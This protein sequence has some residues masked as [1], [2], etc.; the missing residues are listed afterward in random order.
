MTFFSPR[1]LLSRC[2]KLKILLLFFL[3]LSFLLL[4]FLLLLPCLH[5]PKSRV[6]RLHSLLLSAS[7]AFTLHHHQYFHY[8]LLPFS[9]FLCSLFLHQLSSLQ[10]PLLPS[11]SGRVPLQPPHLSR[12]RDPRRLTIQCHLALLLHQTNSNIPSRMQHFHHPL[13]NNKSSPRIHTPSFR[14]RK[15]PPPPPFLTCLLCLLPLYQSLHQLLPSHLQKSRNQCVF[16]FFSPY[17]YH[18]AK[19]SGRSCCCSSWWW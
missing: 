8:Y 17:S 4:S 6:P 16:F 19:C 2:L 7:Y 10:S 9:S 18:V 15:P 12:S 5:L 3:L 1:P 11:S 14:Q 13:L